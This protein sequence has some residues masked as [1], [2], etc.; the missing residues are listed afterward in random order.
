LDLPY[1]VLCAYEKW[2][3]LPKLRTLYEIFWLI[4]ASV[5]WG[6]LQFILFFGSIF[7]ALNGNAFWE[8]LLLFNALALIVLLMVLLISYW[9]FPFKVLKFRNKL[10]EL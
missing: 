2:K 4:E 10:F 6:S 9:F 1:L 7:L 3:K 8:V 5:L